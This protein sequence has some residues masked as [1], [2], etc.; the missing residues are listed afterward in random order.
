M[1]HYPKFIEDDSIF[2]N[3]SD[4]CNNAGGLNFSGLTCLFIA[5]NF[6]SFLVTIFQIFVWVEYFAI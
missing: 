5:D 6:H 3:G 4:L 1:L 2:C